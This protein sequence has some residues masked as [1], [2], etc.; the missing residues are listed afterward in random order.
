MHVTVITPAAPVVTWA[1]ADAHL[2]LDGDTSQ[3]TL[4]EA[5]I[6]SA[7]AWLDGPGGWLGRSLGTQTLEARFDRF[8]CD[9]VKLP[10]GPVISVGSVKYLDEDGDEQT[11]ATSVY[12]LLTDG[13]VRLNTDE[14]WPDLYSDEQAV[15]IRY[16]AG[17]ATVPA[18]IKTAIL[19]MTAFLFEQREASTDDALSSGAVKSLLSPYRV[20]S[21]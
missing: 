6:A 15:R 14:S 12:Q 10:Y 2:R 4:V 11:L 13:R 16:Q 18:P 1:E 9:E 19:L 17:Y 7:T 8:R 21:L 5:L 20:W 3:Q